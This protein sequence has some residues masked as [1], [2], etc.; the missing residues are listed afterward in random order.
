[1]KMLVLCLCIAIS[2]HAVAQTSTAGTSKANKSTH[3]KNP[4]PTP[5][6]DIEPTM[7]VAF[8]SASIDALSCMDSLLNAVLERGPA[9][10]QQAMHCAELVSKCEL[11]VSNKPE[12]DVYGP[13]G[14]LK[15]QLELCRTY[16]T[17][18]A[19]A[20]QFGEC[21]KSASTLRS[22][23]SDAINPKGKTQQ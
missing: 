5:T 14:T 21:L 22:K 7:S 13:L 4:S 3:G 19:S 12:R 17:G 10:S 15:L 16:A 20:D 1:M 8:K 9:Y 18:T 6:P 11:L 2:V 23:V